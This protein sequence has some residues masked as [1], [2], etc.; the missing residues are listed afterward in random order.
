MGERVPLRGLGLSLG[1][2]ALLGPELGTLALAVLGL[3]MRMAHALAGLPV[4]SLRGP[5]RIPVA[6]VDMM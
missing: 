4:A 2:E 6:R 5:G 1:L 3:A